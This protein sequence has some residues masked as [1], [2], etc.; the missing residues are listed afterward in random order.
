MSRDKDLIE[1]SPALSPNSVSCA[2]VY[3]NYFQQKKDSFADIRTNLDG[4]F[5]V[6][7]VPTPK[8]K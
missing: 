1:K 6:S 4:F 2:C 5:P 8:T 7:R 3:T